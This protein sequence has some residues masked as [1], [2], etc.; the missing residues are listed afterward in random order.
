MAPESVKT[1]V[2][3]SPLNDLTPLLAEALDVDP[4]AFRFKAHRI[5]HHLAH[6]ASSYFISPWE[7]A[8]GFTLDGSGD[9]VTCMLSRCKG[10]EISPLRRIFVPHSLGSLYTMVCEFIGYGK[11]GDEGKVMGLAPLGRDTYCD[12]VDDMILLTPDGFEA[13]LKYFKPLGTSEGMS[14]DD[15]G[16]MKL[17]RHFADYM[18]ELFGEPR[19]PNSEITRRDE[20]LAFAL[21]ARDPGGDRDRGRREG[22]TALG[23]PRPG[24]PAVR[25]LLHL[26][27]PRHLSGLGAVGR[28]GPRPR[29]AAVA[30]GRA[31]G[32]PTA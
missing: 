13:N 17:H 30:P 16:Q 18:V 8:A 32:G 29:R 31:R 25:R 9:F 19:E 1:R 27:L 20:D 26:A 24:S 21:Q 4:A 15:T 6:T 12:A 10:K 22:R 7:E 28:D 23:R 5:E 2:A 14:I 11:Y 3:R